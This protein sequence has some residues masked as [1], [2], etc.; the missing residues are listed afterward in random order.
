MK[1]LTSRNKPTIT[2]NFHG[3]QQEAFIPSYTT[4]DR[5]QGEVGITAQS[6]TVF[7]QLYITLEGTAKTFVENL[8]T[9]SPTNG[10]T[11]AFQV[12]LRLIQPIDNSAF[13]ESRSL[14]GGQTYNI[15]FTFVIPERLLPQSCAHPNVHDRVQNAHLNLPPSLGDPMTATQ[16]NMLLDDMAPEMS[17][18]SYAIKV[19]II[20]GRGRTG[21]PIVA[22][23]SSKKLRIIP[24]MREESLITVSG[25]LKDDY[26]L[27]TEKDL[28]KG[29][30]KGKLGCL[31]MESAQPKSLQLPALHSTSTRPITS[32]ATV[33]VRFDPADEGAK[34]PRL[35][36]LSAKL[37]VAT[38]FTSLAMSEF[39]T[40]ATEFH[41]SSVRGVFVET[42]PF[43][44][45]CVASAQWERHSPGAPIRRD[46]AFSTLSDL[47]IPEASSSYSGKTFYTAKL[48]VPITLPKTS[49]MF[50]PTF[51]SCLV[52][53]VYYLSLYLGISGSSTSVTNSTMQLKLPI[54][55]SSEGNP[56]ARPSISAQEAEAI[57]AREA[58]DFLSPRSVA[59]PSPD[60]VER[61]Q[62]S[63]FGLPSP[64]Y[65]AS[66]EQTLRY[67][68]IPQH[69]EQARLPSLP[70]TL[71]NEF[72]SELPPRYCTRA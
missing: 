65:S 53:R 33:N 42:V 70:M 62:L 61:S 27:R 35:G 18:I 11:Q 20:H 3:S 69:M 40:R 72:E 36:S 1:N 30:F 47:S 54:Q 67:R 64:E 39:P 15:P 50:V 29:M 16:G 66:E 51:H 9:A 71:E 55:I 10:R 57:A 7:D 21:K 44:S 6:D 45:R 24:A 68:L 38:Y 32:M 26:R 63:G 34:P 46:S 43:S 12:F 22:A 5:I 2:I 8:A 23:E 59:P 25:G 31:T 48:L 37:K 19:R 4:L 49:K 41:Y 58:R 17:V 13:A 28:K 56:N 14:K 60:Y 52:S